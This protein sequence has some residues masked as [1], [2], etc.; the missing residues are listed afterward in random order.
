M[1]Q[2]AYVIE[3]RVSRKASN[4]LRMDFVDS[5]GAVLATALQSGA[6][7]RR[8]RTA[9]LMG[10]RNGGKGRHLITFTDATEVV[11]ATP[12]G[13]G[14]ASVTS[15]DGDA[16]ATID[17]G[18]PCTVHDATGGALFSVSPGPSRNGSVPDA[19]K[20]PVRQVAKLDYILHDPSGADFGAV[21][22]VRDDAEW[23]LKE[24][25]KAAADVYALITANAAQSLPVKRPGCALLLTR[26]PTPDERV[27]LVA[28][29]VDLGIGLR[30]FG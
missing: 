24:G 3:G 15:A 27:A 7:P 21:T 30:D 12:D 22:E 5:T 25:F 14:R 6:D 26:V 1:T 2:P 16:L 19:R 28:L 29:A 11:I 13:H 4:A 18:A 17:P 9:I 20:V 8:A 23:S 10:M